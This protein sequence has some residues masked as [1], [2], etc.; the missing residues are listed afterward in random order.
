[1]KSKKLIFLNILALI[2]LFASMI[3]VTFAWFYFPSSKNLIIN[4]APELE[5]DIDLYHLEANDESS[6]YLFKKVNAQDGKLSVDASLVFFHWGTEFICESNKDDYYA[7][8]ATYDSS[9]FSTHGNLKAILDA[10]IECSS[11]S[12]YHVDETDE[13]INFR[14]PVVNVSYAI[15]DNNMLNLTTSSATAAA[16]NASYTKITLDGEDNQADPSLIVAGNVEKILSSLATN[17]YIETVNS[18]EHM[19]SRIK[20]IIFIK[21]TAD[22]KYVTDSLID[23]ERNFGSDLAIIVTNELTIDTTFRSVPLYDGT[24]GN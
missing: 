16:R 15:A 14:I 19:S 7:I 17:Q 3:S 21:V 6:S 22:E 4:T 1:M 13:D 10:A 23:I 12:Y 11:D 2:V 8:V 9:A 18:G 24:N 5:I 20:L